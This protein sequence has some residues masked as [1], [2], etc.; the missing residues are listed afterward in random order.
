M[1]NV[2]LVLAILGTVVPWWFFGGFF[3]L[4]GFDVI[5]FLAA[6]Y[7]NGAAAGFSTDV[8]LSILVF[9]IWS[10]RDAK[11]LAIKQWW[12]VLPTGCTV[13]LSLALPL[14]LYWRESAREPAAA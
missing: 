14:Y 1:K 12:W 11:Q 5:G 7:V 6:L 9:W 13:G 10:F 8:L 3:A 2:Y 4:N